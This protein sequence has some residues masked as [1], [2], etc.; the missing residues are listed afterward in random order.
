MNVLKIKIPADKGQ[1]PQFWTNMLFRAHLYIFAI[2]DLLMLVIVNSNTN[3]HFIYIY[4]YI[5]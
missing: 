4:D 5:L 3:Y 2:V 1:W